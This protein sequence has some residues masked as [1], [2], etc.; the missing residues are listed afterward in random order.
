MAF[1][2]III[3]FKMTG[4]ADI[5]TGSD[6]ILKQIAAEVLDVNLENINVYTSDTDITP[7]DSG[8][9]ASSTTYTTGNAVINVSKK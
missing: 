8:A 6:I 4:A 7:F 5:G 2:V 9:Y 1:F 3:D